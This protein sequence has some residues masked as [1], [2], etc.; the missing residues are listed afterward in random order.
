MK[1]TDL[2]SGELE[3][4]LPVTTSSPSPPPTAEPVRS[5]VE[6]CFPLR[7]IFQLTDD[8]W[9]DTLR[10]P[11]HLLRRE[12][13]RPRKQP[14]QPEATPNRLNF[15]LQ[16]SN[17]PVRYRLRV[18][19][20]QALGQIFSISQGLGPQATP[21]RHE[22]PLPL[23]SSDWKSPAATALISSA[24]ATMRLVFLVSE[25]FVEK[26][27]T[28]V[29]ESPGLDLKSTAADYKRGGSGAQDATSSHVTE[30]CIIG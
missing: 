2:F 1:Q 28:A 30:N 17:L 9:R 6:S 23:S 13:R 25:L 20:C 12:R 5:K 18:M 24:A 11:L 4:F 14:P 27:G 7:K 29:E 8:Q 22:P 26:S 19:P 15:E 3:N 21:I 16:S 10:V